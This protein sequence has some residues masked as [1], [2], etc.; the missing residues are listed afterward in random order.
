M[1]LKIKSISFYKT[2][3]LNQTCHFELIFS[4]Y[5]STISQYSKTVYISIFF[6]S[7]LLCLHLKAW[8][9]SLHANM[10]KISYKCIY[11]ESPPF[12][13]LSQFIY[14]LWPIFQRKKKTIPFHCKMF[15]MILFLKENNQNTII[16]TTS[17]NNK[18]SQ[19][20]GFRRNIPHIMK[21]I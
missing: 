12:L 18:G 17:T 10:T 19:K 15:L 8:L 13:P 4:F 21:T 9:S 2:L 14:H 3:L 5:M 7:L 16:L 11:L 1:P 20:S 6:L